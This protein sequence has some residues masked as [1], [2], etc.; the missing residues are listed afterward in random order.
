M[1]ALLPSEHLVLL[2]FKIVVQVQFSAFSPQHLILTQQSLGFSRALYTDALV[3]EP[4]H[5]REDEADLFAAFQFQLCNILS[6]SWI[7]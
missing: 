7:S 1:S 6:Y 4:P 3:N 2:F 5:G